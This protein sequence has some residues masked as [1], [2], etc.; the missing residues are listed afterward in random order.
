MGLT[1]RGS[2]GAE[3][4][5]V[6]SYAGTSSRLSQRVIVPEAACRGWTIDAWGVKRALPYR[7]LPP[8]DY[9]RG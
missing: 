3:A 2:K 5:L 9:R 1:L 4:S 6:A 8:G 7:R